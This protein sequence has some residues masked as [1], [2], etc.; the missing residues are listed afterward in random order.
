MQAMNT[1]QSPTS[2]RTDRAGT[3]EP[4]V[5]QPIAG[6][7]PVADIITPMVREGGLYKRLEDGAVHCYACAHNCTIKPGR[8][9]ICQVR[10]NVG[11]K[12][13]V[14][15]GYVGALQCDPTEKKP[16]FHI[17]PGSDT[18]TFGMLGC[19]LHCPYCQ[20][21]DISQTLRD[22]NAGRPPTPVTPRTP[23]RYRRPSRPGSAGRPAGPRRAR[24]AR[25][26]AGRPGRRCSGR[27]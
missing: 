4:E 17:Y 26:C 22:A 9:G 2:R 23:R 13:H 11:G 6:D 18:L 15:W 16:F 7:V 1:P 14:P 5:R 20:N 3:N 24:A 21:W 8:R 19:D 10:Y 12:L 27:R 25:R